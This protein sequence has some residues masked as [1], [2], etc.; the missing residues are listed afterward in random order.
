MRSALGALALVAGCTCTEEVAPVLPEVQEVKERTAPQPVLQS[1]RMV[2]PLNP[3]AQL[4]P[5]ALRQAVLA[6]EL[7]E[8]EPPA[9]G[10]APP[11]EP[12]VE[13][14][15]APPRVGP[16]GRRGPVP[17]EAVEPWK[18]REAL[19]WPTQEGALTVWQ[20]AVDGP[21]GGEV[22]RWWVER[23]R[24]GTTRPKER[25]EDV[26]LVWDGLIETRTWQGTSWTQAY[27]ARTAVEQEAFRGPFPHDAKWVA[28]ASN[29]PTSVPAARA[30]SERWA[31]ARP[32][33]ASERI[34]VV[35]DRWT[36]ADGTPVAAGLTFETMRR[37]GASKKGAPADASAAPKLEQF[38]AR[39]AASLGAAVGGAAPGPKEALSC[40]R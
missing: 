35:L 40:R 4:D 38:G 27:E 23:L 26:N 28:E 7:A 39:L 30:R 3:T 21:C 12:V 5:E 11:A 10:E 2:I 19:V 25:S 22:E 36:C 20:R 18:C 34:T 16:R 33:V 13:D 31:I 32:T 8:A 29:T 15:D 37:V 17:L 6:A 9:E 14:P 1:V 24:I